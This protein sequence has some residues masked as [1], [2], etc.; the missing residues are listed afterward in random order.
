MEKMN[1]ITSICEH[2]NLDIKTKPIIR[3][4]LYFCCLGCSIAN[5]LIKTIDEEKDD[6]LDKLVKEKI[7]F[8]SI[9][10]NIIIN[11]QESFF[12]NGINCVSCSPIIEK[13]I[14]N[15]E[16]V[17]SSKVNLIS[18]K[19][20]ISYDSSIFNLEKTKKDLKKFGYEL[21]TKNQ[22]EN[23]EQVTDMYLLKLALVWFLSMDIMSFS[24]GIYYAQ[25]ENYKEVIP[26]VIYIQMFLCTL[27]IFVS[28]FSILKSAF[29]K[30]LKGK[31]SMETL[32]SFGAITAYSYSVYETFI[33]KFNVYYD[34]ASMI[35][36]FVL[37]GKFLESSSK[38]KAG[39]TI[40]K[41]M[42]LGSKTA[43]VIENEKEILKNIEDVKVNDLLIVKAGEKIPV[44]GFIIEGESYI[45][46][47]MLTGEVKA[48]H[49]KLDDKVYSATIN[50]DGYFIFKATD[51]GENTTLAKIIE[52]VE[53]AQNEKTESQK[54]ADKL[55]VYF[56]PIV[57]FLS[58][59]TFVLWFYISSNN[60]IALVNAI[61]VLVVACPCALGLAAPMATYTALDKA[62]ELG[63]IIKNSN[64]IEVI[65]K[66]DVIFTDKT[67]TLTE[68]KMKV[69]NITFYD[70]LE[71]DHNFILKILGSVEKY[72]EHPISKAILNYVKE[73]NI[74]L[75]NIKDF[76]LTKGMG[77]E[78]KFNDLYI[79]I[80]SYIFL[81]TNSNQINDINNENIVT[82]VFCSI[83]DKLVCS[84]EVEDKIKTGV[85]ET[86]NY[87]KQKNIKVVMIT[88]DNKVSAEKIAKLL[89]LEEFYYEKLP[90]DKVDIILKAKK[91]Q[92]K[93]MMIGDGINDAPSLV[94]ADIGVAIS[95]AS[96]ISIESADVNILRNDFES[97]P[98]IFEISYLSLHYLKINMIW[99]FSYN[100]ISIPLAMGG[101][102]K[103]IVASAAMAISSLL[104]VTNSLRLRRKI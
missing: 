66:I 43:I 50:Q 99:A 88:G 1:N 21:V 61:A 84:I 97:I 63:I 26:F 2:C 95:N 60:E 90:A 22:K 78:G 37:L 6:L 70:N 20:K 4:Q 83:N 62:A 17:S 86:L 85:N 47:S 103:P 31:L 11:N 29:L 25:L 76:K 96:D 69:S 92:K 44:D 75:E 28:G 38:N 55:S 33:G 79:K 54:L 93:V 81:N 40:K 91:E 46:E 72:S 101:I 57:I 45:D 19:V 58:V 94:S 102:L 16:G 80:G 36:A 12:I 13:I 42:N 8:S 51:V 32:V 3:E 65:N 67:G 71:L 10:K 27:V 82:K 48:I 18:E 49:K 24:L 15:Q 34:T 23:T 5:Q 41:L 77:I 64:N 52:L 39:Q 73:K 7:N 100:F 14:E 35:I 98:K 104:I 87:F 30:L 74:E 68:G 89:D 56:I 59:L 9:N 53:K